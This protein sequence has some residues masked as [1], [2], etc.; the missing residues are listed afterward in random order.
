M[1]GTP[2][3]TI[4]EDTLNSLGIVYV[5]KGETDQAL[6]HYKKSLAINEATGNKRSIA[7]NLGNIGEAYIGKGDFNTALDYFKRALSLYRE[8]ENDWGLAEVLYVLIREFF[9]DLPS[10]T[11]SSYLDEFQEINDRRGEIPLITQKFRLAKAIAL[12]KS[13]R[14]TEKMMALSIFQEVAEEDIVWYELTVTAMINLSELLLFELKTTGDETVL[15]DVK[16]LTRKLQS[17]AETQD[18]YWLLVET[19]ILQSKLALMELD[20]EKAQRLL[21]DADQIAGK[22]KFAQLTKTISVEQDLLSS[23]FSK[24]ERIISQNPSIKERIELTQLN[25]LLERMLHKKYDEQEVYKYAEEARQL[26]DAWGN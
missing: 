18:S 16:K 1:K 2:P 14:L 9:D 26:V 6:T 8:I 11:T 20:L 25:N 19:Y 5:N 23:Q 3:L 21:T 7:V 22:K 24:W 12:K 10:A 13:V 4:K 17:I 15:N